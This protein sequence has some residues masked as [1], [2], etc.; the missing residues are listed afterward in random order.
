MRSF[1]LLLCGVAL[2]VAL[3]HGDVYLHSPPGSNNRLNEA[4]Q[5]RRNPNRVFD[6]QNN[7]RGGYNVGEWCP[8]MPDPSNDRANPGYGAVASGCTGNTR[9]DVGVLAD[10]TQTDGNGANT[11]SAPYRFFEGSEMYIEWTQQHS[12]GKNGKANCQIVIQY[13]CV[14]ALGAPRKYNGQ[15][16]LIS[17]GSN[18]NDGDGTN[19]AGIQEPTAWYTK[20]QTRS[21]NRGLWIADQ[22][23]GNAAQNT[24]QNPGGLRSGNECPE[25][26]D[27]YPYW[28][29]TTWRDIAVLTSE[30]EKR[31]AY[32][33]AQS[34]NNVAREE[35]ECPT[36]ASTGCQTTAQR[37]CW[38]FNNQN[39]CTAS[40]TCVWAS[41]TTTTMWGPNN[42]ATGDG[43]NMPN[44]DC[45]EA[46]WGRDNHLGNSLD[47]LPPSY[48]WKTP[49]TEQACGTTECRCL[50][51]LRYNITT[52]DLHGLQPWQM[53]PG[54]NTTAQYATYSD[55]FNID[56]N[57]NS[58]NPGNE[59]HAVPMDPSNLNFFEEDPIVNLNTGAMQGLAL[60]VDTAQ[61]PRTFQ[62]RT[63]VF[64]LMDRPTGMADST[65]VVNVNVRG[66]RG[67]IVQVYPAVEYDYT[68]PDLTVS[69]D[70]WVVFQWT[71]SNTTPAGAGQGAENTDRSNIVFMSNRDG[72]FPMDRMDAQKAIRRVWNDNS[73]DDFIRDLARAGLTSAI[74]IDQNLN[75]APAYYRAIPVQLNPGTWHFM[76]SRNNNFSNRSQK[77]TIKV[78]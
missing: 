17:D 47:G 55:A 72:N 21:R 35:C 64:Y 48:L 11:Q 54:V 39:A 66:R 40:G 1:L 41:K 56:S 49:T 9:N 16:F 2:L 57:F 78:V 36:W 53:P 44:V 32:Y 15:T 77:F 42:A 4:E 34:F 65:R 71:G 60:A 74:D 45:R 23:V 24:R 13:E 33:R 46:E 20:C 37:T 75:N 31:C 19:G 3:V 61:T 22:N 12:C 62:D 76:C 27:H 50:L 29:P 5:N 10:L 68:P 63:H 7:D 26:R 58:P 25:E 70:D 28:H 38:T 30:P 67:N 51:R 73:R 52:G 69:Q 8:N 59:R 14:P 43:V 6:S 18:T